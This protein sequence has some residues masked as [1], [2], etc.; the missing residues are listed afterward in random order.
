MAIYVVAGQ[1]YEI[2]D[3]IPPDEAI[4]IAL[5]L[6]TQP[7]QASQEAAQAPQG[8]VTEASMTVPT[9]ETDI[10][11]ADPLPFAEPFAIPVA[12][13][14]EQQLLDNTT[15]API[16]PNTLIQNPNYVKAGRIM[17]SGFN[18]R[19]F[20]GTDEELVQWTLDTMGDF[21]WNMARG[22][23]QSALLTTMTDEEKASFGLVMDTYDNLDYSWGGAYRAVRGIAT[24]P[25]TYIGLGTVGAGLIAKT[26]GKIASK[27][28]V[29][30]LLRPYTV[31]A[32]AII[33]AAEG[34]IWSATGDAIRQSAEVQINE[35]QEFS[36]GRVGSAAA[37]GAGAGAVL[38]GGLT[39]IVGGRQAFKAGQEAAQAVPSAGMP[40]VGPTQPVQSV[41][42]PIAG[43]VAPAQPGFPAPLSGSPRAIKTTI[44][45]QEGFPTPLI[46]PEPPRLS[47][48][49]PKAVQDAITKDTPLDIA[50]VA[51]GFNP[52]SPAGREA[53]AAAS[54]DFGTIR[55][56][57]D[58]ADFEKAFTKID[59]DGAIAGRFMDEVRKI[60][61]DGTVANLPSSYAELR[62]TIKPVVELLE[63]FQLR[64]SM[65]T[66]I[67]QRA[68]A[69]PEQ[70]TVI[71]A[72]VNEAANFMTTVQSRLTELAKGGDTEALETLKRVSPL[73]AALS[74]LDSTFGSASGAELGFRA[75]TV[76]T[77]DNKGLTAENLMLAKGIDPALATEQ[78]FL[79]ANWEMT[80]LVNKRLTEIEKSKKVSE[81]TAK[82]DRALKSNDIGKALDF[83][84][85][86]E[87]LKAVIAEKQ[88]FRA[89]VS[90]GIDMFNEA[91]TAG[92]L[93]TSTLGVNLVYPMTRMMA[94]PMF[95]MIMRGGDEAARREMAVAY[96]TMLAAR[97]RALDTAK[98]YIKYHDDILRQSGKEVYGTEREKAIPGVIGT[99]T[100]FVFTLLGAS[101]QAVRLM[102]YESEVAAEAAYQAVNKAKEL[103]LKGQNKK[104]FIEQA[105][106]DAT[107][108][109]L[110]N[111]SRSQEVIRMIREKGIKNG[112]TGESL[113][114]FVNNE[115][116]AKGHLF[117][118]PTNARVME[119]VKVATFGDE[120]GNK[121]L[122]S[123]VKWLDQKLN[124]EYKAGRTLFLFARATMK[125]FKAGT[126]VTPGFQFLIGDFRKDL[127][128]VNG[129][130]AMIRA[131]ME[132]MLGYAALMGSMAMM[133]NGSMTG[134]LN[135][136]YKKVRGMRDAG[137]DPYSM[138]LPW[139]Q[140]LGFRNL[141]PIS[142][143]LKISANF[144]E[145]L[146][147]IEAGRMQNPEKGFEFGTVAE[148]GA[149][150]VWSYIQALRDA[151][152]GQGFESL[153]IA[154][155]DT[156]DP[157]NPGGT[158]SAGKFLAE[159][160]QTVWPSSFSK[161]AKIPLLGGDDSL[162]PRTASQQLMAR[163]YPQTTAIPRQ[164]DYLGNTRKLA[165]TPL[166]SVL[167][168]ELT[169]ER[170]N[171]Q[172]YDK[173]EEAVIQ[174]LSQIERQ[175]GSV[176]MLP[177]RKEPFDGDLREHYTSE[178]I[179]YHDAWNQEIAKDPNLVN[180]LYRE[181][182]QTPSVP[183]GNK[184]YDAW[185]AKR[186]KQLLTDAR[187]R[188]W[189]RVIA[190]EFTAQ[191]MRSKAAH[192]K[193]LTEQGLKEVPPTLYN[194]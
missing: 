52:A 79:D 171:G 19:A 156:F 39:G 160:V 45:A 136:D 31:R 48:P 10:P 64:P 128:G 77:G 16:D 5:Q 94:G 21:N 153:Y 26:G 89:R 40:P 174:K 36:W 43:A 142:T 184:E 104:T 54:A 146:M 125:I 187:N 143:P 105:V 144:V 112:H 190:R 120:L 7:S 154:V 131:N 50:R 71:K 179:T 107:D 83:M 88:G 37:V 135:E 132:L 123:G 46:G 68:A 34:G 182:V 67:V 159:K 75:G 176:L 127:A 109:G 173:K 62:K 101:D 78:Q 57:V 32:A 103:G 17:Y 138:E 165:D 96:G 38:G 163:V 172:K 51:D 181:L 155:R 113:R 133:A 90:L 141:D 33:G 139:G 13:P 129:E 23:I 118:E 47:T 188:A 42:P 35:G 117:V 82:I 134:A 72:S 80:Q 6:H 194:Q 22:L 49:I 189:E 149:A 97:R 178:G 116:D 137:Y 162:E 25:T 157:E 180:D 175:T 81:L 92:A 58:V 55:R 93:S 56:V 145:A 76:L 30:E 150:A 186:A 99:A 148:W 24:D 121:G 106:K 86:E 12:P 3:S 115:L 44:P 15:P 119:Q 4:A 41:Q 102:M 63:R 91:A 158:V 110:K 73:Q 164:Y 168:I 11:V 1:E 183:I 124:N 170:G 85:E 98:L 177:R 61:P 18:K 140:R 66:D 95:Q 29:K 65:F 114:L 130:L 53:A 27:Q 20:E 8:A 166:A 126:R 169:G 191:D 70:A 192:E 151:N 152:L 122:E 108:A 185:A 60:A 87:A 100:R 69:S 28:L 2:D 161:A 84:D 167:G 59:P 111:V 147:V 74:N 193:W 14:D 9:P